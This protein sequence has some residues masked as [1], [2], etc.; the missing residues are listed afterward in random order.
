MDFKSLSANPTGYNPTASTLKILTRLNILGLLLVKYWKEFKKKPYS[1]SSYLWLS[2]RESVQ[3]F[4]KI[5]QITKFNMDFQLIN[6][7]GRFET[8]DLFGKALDLDKNE[9]ERIKGRMVMG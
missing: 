9:I 4:W 7:W 1:L 3:K 8:I 2:V 5:Y 6:M